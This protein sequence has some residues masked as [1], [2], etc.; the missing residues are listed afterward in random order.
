MTARTRRAENL[1]MDRGSSDQAAG[2]ADGG[3]AGKIFG[4]G[5]SLHGCHHVLTHRV[6]VRTRY[7]IRALSKD[8]T[9]ETAGTSVRLASKAFA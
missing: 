9:L 1:A 8:P 6:G 2:G 4:L 5:S 3:G 7:G